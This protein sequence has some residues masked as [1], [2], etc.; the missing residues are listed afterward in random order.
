VFDDFAHHPTAIAKTLAGVRASVGNRRVMAI[1]EPRSNTMKSGVHKDTLAKSLS[2][3]D[4][5]F[6]H[7]DEQV[8]WSV[9]A[10]V[11]DCDQPCFVG[12][13]I[14]QM[15]A[16]IVAKTQAGDTLVVMSNGDFGGIHE[17]LLSAL[18]ELK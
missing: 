8:K 5:V 12:Q 9:K 6:I 11:A 10:L 13:D 17:K 15:V 4:M 7:Q 14:A 2:D 3:A 1:L 18:A 16:N